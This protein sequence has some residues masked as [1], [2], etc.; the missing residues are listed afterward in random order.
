MSSLGSETWIL[1]CDIWEL[2]VLPEYFALRLRVQLHELYSVEGQGTQ[3]S[4]LGFLDSP[5]LPNWQAICN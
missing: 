3:V 2:R 1:L 5:G 4:H